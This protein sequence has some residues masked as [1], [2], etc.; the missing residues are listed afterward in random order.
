MGSQRQSILRDGLFHCFI[1]PMSSHWN[2]PNGV[3]GSDAMRS[4]Y[5]KDEVQIECC[6]GKHEGDN[7]CESQE[8]GMLYR[9]T[10]PGQKTKTIG[11]DANLVVNSESG[12]P[13]YSLKAECN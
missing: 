12:E 1:G 4:E 5:R 6:K 11:R 3:S 9:Q 8:V 13:R 10:K 2:P 7:Y